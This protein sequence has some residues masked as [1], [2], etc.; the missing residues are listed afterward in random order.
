MSPGSYGDAGWNRIS[1]HRWFFAGGSEPIHLIFIKPELIK[2]CTKNWASSEEFREREGQDQ[3]QQE[4]VTRSP[5]I[6]GKPARRSLILVFQL[7][8]YASLRPSNLLDAQEQRT[9]PYRAVD[10][11]SDQELLQKRSLASATEFEAEAPLLRLK[12]SGQYVVKLRKLK[13]YEHQLRAPI[14]EN[15]VEEIDL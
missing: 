9:Y 7:L 14:T 8:A 3:E 12:K 15:R 6:F 11:G 13:I 1:S 5:G 4:Q 10:E 2:L